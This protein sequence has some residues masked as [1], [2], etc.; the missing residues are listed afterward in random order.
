[1]LLRCDHRVALM[2]GA[3]CRFQHLYGSFMQVSKWGN[4]LAVRLPPAGHGVFIGSGYQGSQK[5]SAVFAPSLFF[6][7]VTGNRHFPNWIP[8]SSGFGIGG[9]FR[10]T[11]TEIL[12]LS[13][14]PLCADARSLTL[15][16]PADGSPGAISGYV[17]TS[18]DK[19]AMILDAI[20]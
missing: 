5:A 19:D 8:K 10:P 2:S 4:S 3:S 6:Y 9:I 7:G 14:G 17:S 11:K 13:R 18:G 16:H 12:A 1:M 20:S 15:W